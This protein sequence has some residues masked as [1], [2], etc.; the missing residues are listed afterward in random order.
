VRAPHE[1]IL[2]TLT[3][4]H[5]QVAA[6]FGVTG[7]F[8]PGSL[9]AIVGPNGAGK[10]TLLHALVG[11]HK[12]FTGRIYRG[13]LGRADI[14]LLPQASQLDRSFPLTCLETVAMGHW[15]RVGP[16]RAVA[17]AQIAASRRALGEVGLEALA[18]NPIGRLSAGQFQRVL[19]ARLLVQD[20]PVLLLDEPFNAVD[21]STAQLIEGLILR[22]HEEGRTVIAVL[23]DMDLVRRLFPTTLLLAK[24]Q[25]DWGPTE[26]VLSAANRDQARAFSDQWSMPPWTDGAAP[27][28]AA[29]R[30]QGDAV[31]PSAARSGAA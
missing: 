18:A 19:V 12:V 22:W 5:G 7:S 21:A 4:R 31:V 8:P 24:V 3:L 25:V 30:A 11:L 2:E 16:W 14:A 10:T 1:I 9:T 6:V 17:P 26:R 20:A 23:H 29:V 28:A 27:P 15:G 13:D